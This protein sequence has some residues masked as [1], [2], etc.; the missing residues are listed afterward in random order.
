MLAG[1][2]LV[3]VES[4]GKIKNIS[5]Y[6]GPEYDIEASFGHVRDIPTPSEMPADMKKGPFGK[7]GIDVD[8]GFEPYY[9][10]DPDKKKRVS[11]LKKLLK[12]ADELY[13]ATDDDREGEAIAWHLYEALQPKVPVK[14]MVFTE[15]TREAIQRA[16]ANTRQ[17]D[18][19]LVEAQETRRIL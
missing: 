15:I 16:M 9:V 1:R 13:L 17:I 4:P 14:R 19:N 8:N 5:A 18:E 10:V 11:D 3:I 6:L 12:N 7:F 2:K